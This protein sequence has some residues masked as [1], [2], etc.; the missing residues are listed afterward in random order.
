MEKGI[1]KQGKKI[2]KTEEEQVLQPDLALNMD[3]EKP[4]ISY[5]IIG[6]IGSDPSNNNGN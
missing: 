6:N 1:K 5:E 3:E 2:I 4:G